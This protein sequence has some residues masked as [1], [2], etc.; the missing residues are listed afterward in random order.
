MPIL[1]TLITGG[2]VVDGTGGPRRRCDIGIRDGRIAF[3][4]TSQE[5]QAKATV[6]AD[7]MIITPGFID[8]H[9][10]SD[11]SVLGNRDA[12][13]TI[14][15]GVTTEVVGNCGVT[16]APLH[17]ADMA[18]VQGTLSS[19]GYSGPVT[20]RGFG[21]L[22][23]VV[24]GAGTA[25][26]MVWFVG[27]TAL[28]TA[29]ASRAVAEG[30][31][32][33]AEQIRLLEE[34]LDAG[35]IGF[36]SGLEY[37]SGRFAGVE[38]LAELARVVGRRDGMYASHIRNRD[39]ALATAVDEFFDV[40]HRGGTR[41]QLS[42]LNVR[43]GTG[44]L[45]GAWEQAVQ[46]VAD[47]VRHRLASE[48]L[49][50]HRQEDQESRQGEEEDEPLPQQPELV[51]RH[52]L[53]RVMAA[54]VHGEHTQAR[55]PAWSVETENACRP[56]RRIDLWGGRRCRYWIDGCGCGAV[57]CRGHGYLLRGH[58]AGG[59]AGQKLTAGVPANRS[60]SHPN[61]AAPSMSA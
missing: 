26:N 31:D 41:A 46:R 5:L 33:R 36:S 11:W 30:V 47:V 59:E 2:E 21:E 42:H 12:L 44:A 40:V 61:A 60:F 20:W 50:H 37:G 54:D 16:Y 6:G 10:H 13:S 52:R 45:P 38:E 28:R 9:S 57:W 8:P 22:I 56:L 48:Q 49:S 24:H 43:H 53:R 55:K 19:L 18:A 51:R 4:G 58:G 14:H 23:D 35:A 3:V 7:G 32:E 15:Q 25:Q 34:A 17:D 39:A 1:D 27:H 29:A